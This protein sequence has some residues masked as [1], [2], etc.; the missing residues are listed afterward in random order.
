MITLKRTL[1][2]RLSCAGIAFTLEVHTFLSMVP[3]AKDGM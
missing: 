2:A 1:K 3:S